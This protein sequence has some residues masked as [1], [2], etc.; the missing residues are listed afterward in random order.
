MD[1]KAIYCKF[2]PERFYIDE[3]QGFGVRRKTKIV[4]TIGIQV[5]NKN[6]L[7]LQVQL[8]CFSTRV[9]SKPYLCWT[10]VAPV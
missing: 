10:S 4:R 6:Y 7:S 5:P 1:K 2:L 3:F 8:N 9:Y